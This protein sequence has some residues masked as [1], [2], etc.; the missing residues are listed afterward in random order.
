MDEKPNGSQ[1]EQINESIIKQNY[2]E[3]DII[4]EEVK[5]S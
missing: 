5:Q 2:L 3:M 1:F 4:E